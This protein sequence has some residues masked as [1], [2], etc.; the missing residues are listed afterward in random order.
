MAGRR[1]LSRCGTRAPQRLPKGTNCRP[2]NDGATYFA[3]MAAV[4][5][6]DAAS[7]AIVR[8]WFQKVQSW[9]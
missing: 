2:M 3:T 9:R 8:T 5:S 7:E 1:A 6:T 4:K